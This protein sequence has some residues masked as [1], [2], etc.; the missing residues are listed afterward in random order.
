MV[1]EGQLSSVDVKTCCTLDRKFINNVF[2]V[3]VV[4]FG[5]I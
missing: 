1:G 5:V 3:S 2:D 4:S